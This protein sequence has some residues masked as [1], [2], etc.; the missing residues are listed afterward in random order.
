M[1]QL[2]DRHPVKLVRGE[3]VWVFDSAGYR[4]LDAY[5]STVHVGHENPRVAAAVNRMPQDA[6][7]QCGERILAKLNADMDRV[8]FCCTGTEANELALRLARRRTEAAGV[9]VSTG[10]YH[11]H[12]PQ[13][14]SLSAVASPGAVLPEWARAVTVPDPARCPNQDIELLSRRFLDEVSGAVRELDDRGFGVAAI[15]LDPLLTHE[16]MPALPEETL[17]TAIEIVVGAGGLYIADEVQ[18][19]L[20]R[21]GRFFWAHER[22]AI[23]PDIVTVGKSLANGIPIGAVATASD[24]VGPRNLGPARAFSVDPAACAAAQA[25]LEVLEADQLCEGAVQVGAYLHYRLEELVAEHP[26]LGEVRGEGFHQT[27]EVIADRDARTPDSGVA[28]RIAGEMARRGVLVSCAGP[29]ND[30]IRIRP[31]MPFALEHVDLLVNALQE[32]LRTVAQQT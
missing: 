4:Y 23:S 7:A 8:Y 29:R 16:G 6:D 26:L 18:G 20:G 14:A 2:P 32:A 24:L 21:T 19:G 5:N 30:L 13:L 25:T 12:S 28:R 27:L 17:T 9:I 22:Y 1:L 15:L 31:S 10:S 11:G 3:G